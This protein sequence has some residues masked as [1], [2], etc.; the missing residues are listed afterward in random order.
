MEFSEFPSRAQDERAR[1]SPS[2]Q[3]FPDFE[4]YQILEELPRGGQ[5]FVYKATHVATKTRVALK[6][7]GPGF[8]AS[9]KARRYFER[10]ADILSGLQH[11][12]IVSIRDSGIAAGHYYYAMEYI[13]GLEL[14]EYVSSHALSVREIITLF[15]KICDAT[16]YAHQH[17]VIHRD[18]K[19]SNIL[20]DKRGD[21]H[22]LDFGLA[23]TAGMLGD[24]LSVISVSGEIKGTLA[25][26]SPEQASGQPSLIDVRTDVYSLGVILYQLLTCQFPYDVSG[27]AAQI[28]SNI[29]RVEPVR[30]RDR[31]RKCD[32]EVEAIILKSLEKK[33]EERYQSAAELWDDL[34]R[35][36]A[37][38]P[39]I[40]KS[41]SSI[42][43]IRKLAAKHAYASAVLILL[44][45]IVIG[46]TSASLSMGIRYRRQHSQ[47]E[48]T[49]TKLEEAADLRLGLTQQALFIHMLDLWHRDYTEDATVIGHTFPPG[50]REAVA[51]DLMSRLEGPDQ[52]N[53]PLWLTIKE[54]DP[55]FHDFLRAECS[56][57]QGNRQE[58]LGYYRRLMAATPQEGRHELL[59]LR[60]NL[61]I[62]QESSGKD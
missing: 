26:M 36:L 16:T 59:L 23:K 49:Q 20:V 34:R 1:T 42:Y 22:I 50:S 62:I 18:L 52:A 5:A 13:E 43:I 61:F 29:E 55:Q 2:S 19:P 37:G 8:L 10:E 11:P 44:C 40:A 48:N 46:F 4:G 3:P 6:V 38:E 31:D 24:A 12:Y 39:V 17:G 25:Y 32:S 54:R 56:R 57:K 47:L 15:A 14:V 21:P 33:P 7:L 58:A 28:L 41:I 45:V 30:P 35:W 60:A 53:S 9:A 51:F 27:T